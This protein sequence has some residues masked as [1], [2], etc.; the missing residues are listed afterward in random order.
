[1]IV[2]LKAWSVVFNIGQN[3]RLVCNSGQYVPGNDLASIAILKTSCDEYCSSQASKESTSHPARWIKEGTER[4]MWPGGA[5]TLPHLW[6]GLERKPGSF[7]AVCLWSL[8]QTVSMTG[9]NFCQ[10]FWGLLA[11]ICASGCEVNGSYWIC[12]GGRQKRARLICFPRSLSISYQNSIPL[13][14]LTLL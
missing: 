1:M 5:F 9:C 10:V 12:I 3:S 2:L 7:M 8:L 11:L 13:Y 6:S 4:I 14:I